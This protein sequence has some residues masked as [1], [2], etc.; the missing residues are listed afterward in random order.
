MRACSM[1]TGRW[2]RRAR[3]ASCTSPANRY[4][5]AIGTGPRRTARPSASVEGVRWYSTGDLVREDPREGYIYI[6][7]RDRMVKRRGYR[8]ELDDIE[9][10][11]YR[12]A[13]IREAAVVAATEP[14]GVRICAYL[15]SGAEPHPGILEMKM[16][17]AQNLP[18]Y[19]N[20]D[21]FVF[22]T[23]LP[24]TSTNKVDYQSLARQFQESA[25][26]APARA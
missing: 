7:R 26:A 22:L 11:L 16:F 5:R 3:K 2:C 18:S 17:C 8:I 23:A 1:P 13:A 4:F 9:V 12:H 6:G 24:R 15:V 19:M 10:S 20:P 14:S 21:V 25:V